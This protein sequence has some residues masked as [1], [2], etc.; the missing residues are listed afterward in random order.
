MLNLLDPYSAFGRI[1]AN[2]VRPVA[3]AA[4]NLSAVLLEQFGIYALARQQWSVVAPLSAGIALATFA[5]VARLSARHGRLYCNLVCPVGT[6]LGLVSR[7]SRLRIG[8]DAQSCTR[9]RRCED[10]CKAGCID[11]NALTVDASRCVSCFNCLA[12]CPHGAMGFR[13]AWSRS[14]APQTPDTGRRD[15]LMRSG[16]SL[17]GF[18]GVNESSPTMLQSRP[19]TVPE[20]RDHAG[21]AARLRGHRAFQQ[22]LH[23]LPPVR[24]RLPHARADPVAFG[25]R[26]RRSHAAA[27]EQPRRVLQ[28]RLH[29]LLPGLSHGGHPAHC[30]GR[31]RN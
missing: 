16:L 5:L 22:H 15:F 26:L 11:L 19:T 10:V 2:L 31:R 24:Q 30:P 23:R 9:C 4:N 28:L 8:I 1:M 27:P 3:I 12:S 29:H 25:V 14:P 6:L 18:A 7:V 17:L 21:F 13:N 20:A